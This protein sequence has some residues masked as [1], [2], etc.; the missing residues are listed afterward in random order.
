M[1]QTR[2]PV[3]FFDINRYNRQIFRHNLGVPS[4]KDPQS[5][6]PKSNFCTT[7]FVMPVVLI[8]VDISEANI[9]KEFGGTTP[10]G[11]PKRTP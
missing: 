6:P 1:A 8:T 11:L 10:R 5:G 9:L 7:K 3:L 4:P 2:V